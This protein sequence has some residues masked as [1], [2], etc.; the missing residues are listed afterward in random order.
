MKRFPP[1]LALFFVFSLISVQLGFLLADAVNPTGLKFSA[2]RNGGQYANPVP[3]EGVA[4]YYGKEDYRVEL[5]ASQ[6]G[7]TVF[8]T[9]VPREM[10]RYEK[11]GSFLLASFRSLIDLPED[12]EWKLSLF[13]VGNT[14][15]RL[16]GGEVTIQAGTGRLSGEF[17]HF[18]AQ[19]YAGLAGLVLL[20]I[21]VVT[22]ARRST[23]EKRHII[24]FLLVASLWLNE[25]IYQFYWYFTGGWHAAWALMVQ[26][27]GLSILIL[28]FVF[29]LPAGKLRQVLFE[30][31]FF[32]G[33]GGALQALLA[34]DIG[35]RG[36][37][38]YKY[39]SFFISHGLIIAC[40]LYLVA[41][42]GFRPTLMSV[43][44]VILIS[45]IVVFFAWWINLALEHIP[46]F[47]RGNYFVIGFPPP[48]GSI[49]DILAGIFG[50]APWYALG[51]E[52]LGLALFLTMW[53]PFGVK[54]LVRRSGSG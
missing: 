38:E 49:V 12:G 41:G 34:P 30:L 11:G 1:F 19:H 39:F 44:R 24:E 20:W 21:L 31:I 32:W 37:P 48:T 26:M 5:L 35:Y 18:S 43:F 29:A 33:I 54:G 50:P 28:C 13:V 14:G 15:E 23:E 8:R 17:R 6:K 45:N 25:I 3:V 53:L 10:V 40:G 7:E 51:L 47:Q 46:P 4:W 22:A 27:C 36:F 16:K 2:P 52:I 9:E 42:R